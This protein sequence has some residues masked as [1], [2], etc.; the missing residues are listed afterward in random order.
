MKLRRKIALLF[1]TLL[2]AALLLTGCRSTSEKAEPLPELRAQLKQGELDK[3][4]GD[5]YPP[6]IGMIAEIEVIAGEQRFIYARFGS[7]NAGVK[8]GLKGYVYNDAMLNEK[9]GKVEIVEVYGKLSKVKVLELS[10]KV[11]EGGVVYIEVDPNKY[12]E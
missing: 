2:F 1:S 3:E 8:V 5:E 4:S 10:Y 7:Q 6:V 11:Q 9:V 12:I